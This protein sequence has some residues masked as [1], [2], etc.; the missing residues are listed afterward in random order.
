ME[1]VSTI[2]FLVPYELRLVPA[3][4][5]LVK[6]APVKLSVHHVSVVE[7]LTV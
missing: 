7:L 3:K 6:Y 2:A 1:P 5:A 4:N